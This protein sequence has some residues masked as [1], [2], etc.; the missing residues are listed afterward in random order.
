M[1]RAH[2]LAAGLDPRFAVLDEP[3]A[4]RLAGRAY[5]RALEAWAAAAARRRVDLAGRL[6]RRPAGAGPGAHE[7][8]AAAGS[9]PAAADPAADRR[10]RTPRALARRARAAAARARR[11]ATARA[12]AA[13]R[14]ALD[15]CE[16]AGPPAPR[17]AARRARRR[18]S[19]PAG[20]KLLE[21]AACEAYREALGAYRQACADHHA[22]AALVLIDDLLARFGAA[23]RAPRPRAPASTS[24]T[25]SCACATCSPTPAARRA[26]GGALRAAHG[27]RVPGHEPAA[28]RR[29][30]DARARQPVRGRR[31]VPVDLRLPPR[32][33]DDLPRA[34]AR[35]L[36]R[37]S[38]PPAARNFRSREE[39]LDVLNGAFAPELGRAL[40][41]AGRGRAGRRPPTTGPLRLFD[42]D[43]VRRRPAGRAAGHRPARLGRSTRLGL[44]GAREQPWRR[45]EA[46]LVAHRLREEV[47]AGRRPG[48]IAVLV[49]A[50]AS[51]RLLEQALEEHG[52]PTY[53][54]GG[55]GYWSAGA[56]PRRPRLPVARSRTRSTRQALLRRARLAVLRRRRRRARPARRGRPRERGGAVGRAAR[57][58]RAAWPAALP[59]GRAPRGSP[60][61]RRC[62]AAEREQAERAPV[63]VLLERAIAAT[64]YDLAVLARPG[65]ERRLA[66]LRKLMRLAREYERAE[67]RDLRGFLAYA[68]TQDLAEAREGEAA[69]ECEGLDA[70]RL[71]TIHRAKGLEFPVV[72][73]ADLGRAAGG[74]RDRCCS[75]ATGASACGC[76]RSAAASSSPALAYERLADAEQRGGGRGGAAAALRGDDARA[77]E[78][79]PVRGVDRERWPEPRPGGAPLDWIAPALLDD[80]AG[81][82]P[83]AASGRRRA[84]GRPPG[85]A[86]LRAQR[87]RDARRCSARRARPGRPPAR[88][89]PRHRAARPPAR[90][91]GARRARPRPAPQRLSY[92]SLGAYARCGYRFYLQRRARLPRGGAAAARSRRR[93]RGRARR[94]TR[95]RAA[96][97]CT[98]C[99]RTSTSRGPSRPRAE[100]VA[101]DRRAVGARAHRR[102]GRRT[103]ATSSTAFAELAAVRAAGRGAPVAARGAVRVRARAGRRRPARHRLPRRRSRPSPTAASSRRLQDRPPGGRR[104]RRRRRARLRHPAARLRARRA[105]RRRAARRG[106]LLLPRAP[107]RAGHAGVHRRRRERARR[108][109]GRPRP[110]RARRAATRSPTSRT[111]TCAATAPAAR[112]C[113]RGAR[114]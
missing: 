96:R 100:A 24:R 95:V 21:D 58:A 98:S 64:G 71:M 20:A 88:R 5:E 35:A 94:S 2:P 38:R 109:A 113:A 51:L 16:R 65:G 56:G 19:S 80:P 78:A 23:S 9:A 103:S 105:A 99:S 76:R 41:A 60:P 32:R 36:E 30:G 79:D 27:R 86:A 102:R 82:S 89:R 84:P 34:R 68:A 110:R 104:A 33:R 81:A 93:S 18:A 39:L 47:D 53:V 106:R 67:G 77:R 54:V 97:S 91:A 48:E 46:R 1:L 70:V 50:A 7:G 10:R 66:N 15:A 57:R 72:C 90:A 87:A 107:G 85:A 59:D 29:A 4:R 111:A 112:R 55:R 69:L 73:V 63:E 31:R 25:S 11:A 45:A 22:R 61:S 75:A 114:T 37:G 42:P 6:R 40:R 28:A 26:L 101:R 12:S 62:F 43:P 108:A 8:C 14:A 92:T 3:A 74:R 13:A 49:R 44:A 17:P 52:L 83:S